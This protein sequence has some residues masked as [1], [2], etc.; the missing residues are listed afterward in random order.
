MATDV[1]YFEVEGD[2]T[3]YQFND[4]DA[5][6]ALTALNQRLQT[7]EGN[8]TT[9]QGDVTTLDE[10]V[11]YVQGDVAT[12][13]GD[14]ATAQGDIS[15]LQGDMGDVQDELAGLLPYRTVTVS[16]VAWYVIEQGDFVIMW[17]SLTSMPFACTNSG[18]GVYYSDSVNLTLPVTL[19]V[20][21]VFGVGAQLSTLVNAAAAG[22]V[23]SVRVMTAISRTVQGPNICIIGHK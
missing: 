5:E 13:Q 3:L 19:A 20:G 17:A 2:S 7:A 10:S 15:T 4:P 14:V 1:S 22:N 23:A 8:I 12:L 9:L 18:N 11:T 16:G 6:T 21:T